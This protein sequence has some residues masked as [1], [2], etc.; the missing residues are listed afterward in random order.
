MATG[1]IPI[2][3]P[4][5][6]DFTSSITT[7]S[8]VMATSDVQLYRYGKLALFKFRLKPSDSFP[9]SFTKTHTLPL[10]PP[11]NFQTMVP[12][13]SGNGSVGI[14]VYSASG[15]VEVY[16]YGAAYSDWV[17]GQMWYPIA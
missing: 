16:S 10:R 14:F 6:A 1:K 7:V 8:N 11:T 15:D 12:K 4:V 3:S 2:P 17:T 5:W 9:V 13:T